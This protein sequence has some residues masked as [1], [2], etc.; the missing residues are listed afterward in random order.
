[1]TLKKNRTLYKAILYVRETRT[2][3]SQDLKLN[4]SDRELTTT[5]FI[6][7]ILT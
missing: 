7:S 2:G 3:I 6:Y 5:S 4:L 1:M